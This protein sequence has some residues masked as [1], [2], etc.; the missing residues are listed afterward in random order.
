MNDREKSK[1]FRVVRTDAAAVRTKIQRDTFGE[2]DRLLRLADERAR[3]TLATAPT[4]WQKYHLPQ[5][6]KSIRQTLDELAQQASG[7]VNG[8]AGAAWS[9]GVD[10][11]EQPL[12]A[13]GVRI[14]AVLPQ[15]DTQQLLAMRSFMTDKMR[16]ISMTV[17][18]R[19]N[20]HLGLVAIGAQTPGDAVAS[21]AKLFEGGRGR[22]ITVV[23]TELGRAFSTAA[24]ERQQ[25][26]VQVLPGLQKQWRRSGKV[27][28]RLH[29]DA[30][31]GQ[32]QAV[33]QPF[34]LHPKTGIVHL[35]FPRDPQAPAGETVN[36]G[37]ESLPHMAHWDMTHPKKKPF[38]AEEV[39]R[40]RTKRE[41]DQAAKSRRIG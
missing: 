37:C 23:R 2:I 21:I 7:V 13:G 40:S 35:R 27:H 39:A 1:R 11:I 19:I 28:S 36:C 8:A 20:T 33:D 29:H 32:I 26:A 18:N 9:A 34:V 38:T 25:Q 4:D 6:Q 30:A 41:L 16:D 24:Y 15:L 17:A 14:S 10:L 31:D 12:I 3:L 22:A 5:L